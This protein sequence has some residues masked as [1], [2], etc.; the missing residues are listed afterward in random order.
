MGL[1]SSSTIFLDINF[2]FNLLSHTLLFLS[3]NFDSSFFS[4]FS[5][6]LFISLFSFFFSAAITRATN[7]LN[8][9]F[10]KSSC[11]T[12]FDNSISSSVFVTFFCIHHFLIFQQNYFRRIILFFAAFLNVHYLLIKE[13]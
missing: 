2:N 12:K 10:F 13:Y 1:P 5:L 8:I 11:F 3:S 7:F 6:F 4:T 9:I